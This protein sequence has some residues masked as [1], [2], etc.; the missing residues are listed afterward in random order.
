M[1][2]FILQIDDFFLPNLEIRLYKLYD[3]KLQSNYYPSLH[4]GNVEEPIDD[5]EYQAYLKNYLI[6]NVKVHIPNRGQITINILDNLITWSEFIHI[7]IT[8]DD[9]AKYSSKIQLSDIATYSSTIYISWNDL[10]AQ[11]CW[12]AFAIYFEK[13]LPANVVIT[14]WLSQNLIIETAWSQYYKIDFDKIPPGIPLPTYDDL[15]NIPVPDSIGLLNRL[16]AGNYYVTSVGGMTSSAILSSLLYTHK[17]II[18]IGLGLKDIVT[19]LTALGNTVASLS[20][21]PTLLID[22][23]T[24]IV[25]L[26]SSL[27]SAISSVTTIQESLTTNTENIASLQTTVTAQ[28]NSINFLKSSNTSSSANITTLRN[29]IND[30][31]SDI[32]SLQSSVNTLSS[33]VYLLQSTVSAHTNAITALQTAVNGLSH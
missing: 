28:T 23:T 18:D 1:S 16:D 25:S 5:P 6:E 19:N 10:L 29:A 22:N 24:N 4:P 7:Q 12:Y 11:Y 17:K 8:D 27:N 13:Y 32:A 15:L 30:N 9:I 14:D 3:L 31:S 2:V 33:N 21:I 26:Q 20:T